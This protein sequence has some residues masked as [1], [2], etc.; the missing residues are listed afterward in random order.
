MCT[1]PWKKKKKKKKGERERASLAGIIPLSQSDR[2]QSGGRKC[3]FV[4]EG[5]G[6]GQR[7]NFN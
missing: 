7:A 4:N 1:E 2:P 6:G 3:C 5:S